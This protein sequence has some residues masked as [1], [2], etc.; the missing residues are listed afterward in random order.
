MHKPLSLICLCLMLIACGESKSDRGLKYM[1]DMYQSPALK[2]QEAYTIHKTDDQGNSVAIE[3]PGMRVAPNGTVPRHFIPYDF[4]N[5]ANQGKDLSNPLAATADVLE[6]GRDKYDQFCAVCHGKEGDA[7][8][9]Y[10]ATKFLGVP[11][12]N[13]DVVAG[14]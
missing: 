6:L 4:A 10:V 1:P 2:S 7:T 12:V 14:Y 13:S 9:G 8:Q 5:D 11:N 3:V